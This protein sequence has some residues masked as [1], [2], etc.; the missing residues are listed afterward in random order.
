MCASV[1]ITM[2]ICIESMTLARVHAITLCL[3]LCINITVIC[4]FVFETM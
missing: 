4:V 3:Y 2:F 1:N